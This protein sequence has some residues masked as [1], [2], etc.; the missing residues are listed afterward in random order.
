MSS[1]GK[2]V[3]GTIVAVAL[4]AAMAAWWHTYLQ[5]QRVLTLW[6]PEAARRIRLAS[7][8]ELWVLASTDP[9]DSTAPAKPLDSA[10]LVIGDRR[11]RIVRR[12]PVEQAA[13]FV[14]T[15]QAL[16]V[17]HSF[18][19]D[20]VPQRLS[21]ADWEYGLR[22]RDSTGETLLVFDLRQA[23]VMN[24]QERRGANIEPIAQGLRTYF[25]ERL[26]PLR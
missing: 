12:V 26:E 20:S 5:G 15:R 1:P 4:M 21:Q 19:W 13:G 6:G 9:V 3:A 11:W 22:F 25:V 14:H 16:V 24:V 10:E 8:C 23:Q 7:E 18:R 2:W 17:D